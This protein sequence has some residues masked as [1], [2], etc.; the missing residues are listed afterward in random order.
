MVQGSHGLSVVSGPDH[1]LE[2]NEKDDGKI[3]SSS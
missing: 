2:K 3:V 1:V